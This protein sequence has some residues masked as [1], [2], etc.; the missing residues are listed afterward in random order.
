MA[1]EQLYEGNATEYSLAQI[2][3]PEPLEQFSKV[4]CGFVEFEGAR[5]QPGFHV[6]VTKDMQY[7]KGTYHLP[8]ESPI[9]QNAQSVNIDINRQGFFNLDLQ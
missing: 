8:L 4:K 7:Y 1:A 5:G 6:I 3:L 9:I 2:R